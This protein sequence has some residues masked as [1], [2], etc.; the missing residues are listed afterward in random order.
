[1]ARKRNAE[2]GLRGD[3]E[4]LTLPPAKVGDFPL[5]A[6]LG[7]YRTMLT[8]RRLDEKMLTLLKQGKGAFHIGTSGHEAVQV[9]LGANLIPGKD[10]LFPYYRDLT[11]VLQLGMRP[12]QVLLAHL[13][14]AEDPSSGG[15]QMPEHFSYPEL[16]IV[17]P[18]SSV[19]NQLLPAVGCAM[20]IKRLK[21][22]ELVYV[23]IGEG[24]TSQGVWHEALNWAARERLP[25]LFVVQDNK[26]AISVPV[27]QQTAGSGE[28]SG[29]SRIARGY[30]G[31]NVLEFDGTDFFES[32]AVARQAV[33]LAR[34]GQG[35]VVLHA[36]V[37]R[38]LPHSSSDDHRKYRSEEELEADRRR[39]PI[40]RLEQALLEAALVDEADLEA[41][42]LEVRRR[43]DEASD[44]AESR[45]DPDPQTAER[46]VFFEGAYEFAYEKGE[47]SGELI[48]MVDAINHALH[49]EMARDERV[50][51]YGEDVAGPKGGVFTATRGLTERFGAERCFNSPLA[52]A[53]IVGTAIGLAL[54]GFKPVVEIQF[55]DYIWPAMSELRNGLSVIRYR[56]NNGWEAPVVVRVPV[57]GYIHGGLCHSQ[58]IEATFAHFPGW[59]IAFPSNAADAKGLL[60]TAIRLR[61]PVLFLEHKGLYRHAAARR[62]EPDADY[63]VPFGRA[64]VVRPGRDVTV[65]TYGLVLYMALN[66]AKRLAQEEGLE[67]ELIDLRTLVPLDMETVLASVRKTGRVLVLHEDVEFVGFGAEVAAQIADR[68]FEY[69]D[70]PVRRHGGK[71]TPIPFADSLERAVLPQEETVYRAIYELA[72]Y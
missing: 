25:V 34:S 30:E 48:V 41:I 2:L 53:S 70:A 11:L 31:V 1:M 68:A 63:L 71:Y 22:D 20:G 38:L 54:R 72:R 42:R 55:G 57:G 37:V 40:R 14:K 36:H 5:E 7:F 49:E 58:N 62:P 9:A 18:S 65:V 43:V 26:Y 32:W 66:A 15:R 23:G 46:Y 29:I 28:W 35:P 10:W 33:E 67:V 52:E 24:G 13:A 17:S 44:W 27:W 56:S 51:V 69:L 47:P 19:G 45:P 16:R 59:Y 21:V 50:L 3:G 4:V 60:K 8:A 6:L 12:E 39:D 61:D 64:K